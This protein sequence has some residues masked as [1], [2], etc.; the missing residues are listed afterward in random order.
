MVWA[1]AQRPL[2]LHRAQKIADNFDP[3]LFDD[4]VVCGP[5]MDGT[6]HC[7]DGN[8]RK[9]GAELFL[10]DPNQLVP[11]RVIAAATEQRAAEIFVEKNNG[12]R[13][14]SAMDSF[15]GSVTAQ[16]SDH[17][18]VNSLF[19]GL[20]Y[21]VSANA[22]DGA[23]GCVTCC[24]KIYRQYDEKHLKDTLMLLIGCFGRSK[25]SVK[26]EMINGASD[27]LTIYGKDVD[28]ARLAEVIRKKTTAHAMLISAN[29]NKGVMNKSVRWIIAMQLLEYYNK[30][31][32]SSM[33][34]DPDIILARGL[35]KNGNGGNHEKPRPKSKA[36]PALDLHGGI[37][38]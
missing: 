14:L 20:G 7:I 3:D 32:R 25:E 36:S 2:K 23:I 28:R 30:G 17:V 29:S 16:Y 5:V 10:G 19:S 26:A 21:V 34:L 8:T 22:R 12:Q 35:K 27:F 18:V 11:C 1:N 38:T 4:I 15:K 6:F 9:K 13:P 31:L 37:G 24:L 33:R